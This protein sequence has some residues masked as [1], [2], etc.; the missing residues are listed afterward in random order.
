[1]RSCFIRCIVFVSKPVINETEAEISRRSIHH[2][3]SMLLEVWRQRQTEMEHEEVSW[4]VR[5]VLELWIMLIEQINTMEPT[6]LLLTRVQSGRPYSHPCFWFF[7]LSLGR[8]LLSFVVPHDVIVWGLSPMFSTVHLL[9][10]YK[11]IIMMS[12]WNVADYGFET[13]TSS[14][15]T[16]IITCEGETGSEIPIFF[17][18]AAVKVSSV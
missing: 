16:R 18:F 6:N 15:C 14:L 12:H 7:S 8:S 10:L 4:A 3:F 11:R 13:R 17:V 2:N 9:S 1:M 5:S